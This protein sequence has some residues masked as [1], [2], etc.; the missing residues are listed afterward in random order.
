MDC[1]RRTL[2]R[3]RVPLPELLVH[4]GRF[5]ELV[6]LLLIQA[7]G[8]IVVAILPDQNAWLRAGLGVR[9][10]EPMA[11]D[12]LGGT[13]VSLQLAGLHLLANLLARPAPHA[14]FPL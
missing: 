3:K 7:A 4:L 6:P 9:E 10:D 5:D 13:H 8:E 2:S 14:L 1:L 12:H 11:L